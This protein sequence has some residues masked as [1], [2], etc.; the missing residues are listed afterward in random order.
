MKYSNLKHNGFTLVETLVSISILLIVIVG[1]MTISSSAAKSTSYSSEQVV[2]FFLAQEGAEIAQKARDDLIL[3]NF[4]DT[5]DGA[6]RATPWADFTN[7]ATGFYRNCFSARGCALELNTDSTG[8]LKIPTACT[9]AGGCKLYLSTAGNRTSYT[10]SVIGN[11]ETPYTRAITFQS[12]SPDELKVTSRVYWQTGS[13]RQSQEAV[14]E[15][16]LFNVYGN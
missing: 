15:T 6:Y 3:K 10:Y 1:P 14:V 12:I 5:S 11:I 9:V 13:R 2:A 8:S 7:D 4:L 16:Y